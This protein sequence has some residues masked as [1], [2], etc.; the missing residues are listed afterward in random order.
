MRLK[1]NYWMIILPAI[2]MMVL[3]MYPPTKPDMVEDKV[4]MDI[5]VLET[6]KGEI[7]I[8][9][10]REKAQKSVANIIA[11]AESGYYDGTIFHRVIGDFMIQGGGFT[12][13]GKQKK[14]NHPV[15]LES[16]NGLKNE[17]GTIAMARTNDPNSATSQFFINVQDNPSLDNSRGNPGYAVFGRVIEGMDVVDLIRAV[18]TEKRGYYGDWPVNDV[19]IKKAYMR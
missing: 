7:V 9:L 15:V 11:Y 16:Q 5:L 3:W 4:K 14:T 12:P 13:D 17:R 19:V 1:N 8:E 2:F 18:P 10:N 6:S